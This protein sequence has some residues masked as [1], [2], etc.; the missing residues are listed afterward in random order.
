MLLERLL[1][2][3]PDSFVREI[4][5]STLGFGSVCV[6]VH[7]LTTLLRTV[8]KDQQQG[9]WTTCPVQA[10]VPEEA[11]AEFFSN[12]FSSRKRLFGVNL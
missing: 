12:Y 4:R 6:S 1:A 3:Q 11:E 2:Q 10:I 7:P 9:I 5:F 8:Q